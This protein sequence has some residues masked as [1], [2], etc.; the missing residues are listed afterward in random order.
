MGKDIIQRNQYRAG[1]LDF[2]VYSNV[3]DIRGELAYKTIDKKTKTPNYVQFFLNSP[4]WRIRQ[5][6]LISKKGFKYILNPERLDEV[7]NKN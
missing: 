4:K 5:T 6:K 1:D 2:V 3:I 7:Y